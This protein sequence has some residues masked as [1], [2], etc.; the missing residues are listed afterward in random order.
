MTTSETV[1][2]YPLHAVQKGMLFHYLAA[3]NREVYLMQLL[4]DFRQPV[5]LALL[6]EAWHHVFSRHD[7]LRARFRWEG[8]KEPLQEFTEQI[9]LPVEV[10]DW[11]GRTE[12][13]QAHALESFLVTDRRAGFDLHRAPLARL[14]AIRRDEAATW[15]VFTNHHLIM[16]GRGR[17]VVLEEFL[18]AYD[19]LRAG[20]PPPAI[21]C[22]QYTDYLAWYSRQEFSGSLPYWRSFLEGFYE[23][24]SI[25]AAL[26]TPLV[27]QQP[28]CWGVQSFDIDP[29]TGES[30]R[31]L[32]AD[33]GLTLNTLFQAA[34]SLLLCRYTGL[35]D[36]V[37]GATRAARA[38][39][40]EHADDVVGLFINTLPVRAR[41]GDGLKVSTWLR[42]IRRQQVSVREHEQTPLTIVQQCSNVQ[43]GV[44]LF[45]TIMVFNSEHPVDALA[46]RGH[47][48]PPA[49]E[50]Y[51]F[52]NYPVT[53]EIFASPRIVV[54]LDHDTHVID[55]AAAARMATHLHTLLLGVRDHFDGRV[56]DIPMLDA[57]ERR[58]L[59]AT[60]AGP[61]TE[62]TGRPLVHELV[63][64]AIHCNGSQAAVEFDEESLSYR[65]VDERAAGIAVELRRLGVKPDDIVGVC[66]ERSAM[67]P[68]VVLGIL[69]SGAAYAPLDPE[70]PAERLEYI[71]ADTRTPIIISQR[72]LAPKLAS[73]RGE[74]LYIDDEARWRTPAAEWRAETPRDL[75]P[76]QLAYVIYTSGSTG[77]PKGVEMTHEVVANLID[78]QLKEPGFAAGARTLQFASL[79]FDVSFQEILS[80][81]SSGGCLVMVS[82]TDR[83]DFRQLV[84]IVARARVQRMFLPFIA[85]QQLA[86]EV[87]RSQAEFSL[88]E[89]ITA[90]EQLQTTEAIRSMFERLPR[91]TLQNQYGPSETHVVTAHTVTGNVAQWPALPPIGRPIQNTLAY[92]VGRHGEPAPI[93]V[94]GELYLGGVCVA[95]GYRNLATLTAERFVNDPFI[96]G[97]GRL[98]RTGDLA[99][100][101]P[102]GTIE[103]L[104]RADTQVKLRG[105]RIELGEIEAVLERHPVV[106]Q[107]VVALREDA[108]GRKRL[109]AYVVPVEE[110]ALTINELKALLR[111]EVPEYMIPAAFVLMDALPITPSGKI[112]RR[113]LPE[114]ARN[115][116][117]DA[118]DLVTPRDDI[119]RGLQEIWEDVLGVSPIGMTESFFDL[120]G[121]SLLAL[122][123]TDRIFD[124]FGVRVHLNTLWYEGATIE[125]LATLIRNPGERKDS[126]WITPLNT[127][128]ITPPLYCIHTVGGGNLFHYEPMVRHLNGGRT[129]L[130]VEARG[131]S[132][133]Q[134]ADTNIV[135]MGE[136]CM[137]VIQDVQPA[138]PYYL[139][140]FSSGGVV[141]YEVAQQLR[142]RG[143]SIAL[144]AM[145]DSIN[146]STIDTLEDYLHS[147][148]I[149]HRRGKYREIQE[150]TYHYFLRRLGLGGLRR[151]RTL[152]E[153]HRWAL[154][155]YV[156]EPYDG[157]VL[158][159]EAT[160][161]TRRFGDTHLGWKDLVRGRLEVVP[162]T[163]THGLIVKGESAQSIAHHINARLEELAPSHA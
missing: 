28:R 92:I 33:N 44:P 133:G 64:D 58:Q 129:I 119:E 135:A 57:E 89:I 116:A 37:F 84:A 62:S 40:V 97:G 36:V 45:D 107:S 78:W 139:C 43:P 32:A 38:H 163:G 76:Q 83:R 159:F 25:A 151:L 41:F 121:H 123:L 99:R 74:I 87:V 141:A 79:N 31:K 140:G 23:P 117:N 53:V 147:L 128:T 22:A 88:S 138:G 8:L 60:G 66:L 124:R 105:F 65:D 7:A 93:E 72:D 5:D 1:P 160:E 63:D 30:L 69:R 85:L 108:K 114:P 115:E 4:M 109:V 15:L 73:H 127:G 142:M 150:R 103:F 19:A 24:S 110:E 162:V 120:G 14:S 6:R 42:E 77:R 158:L 55:E 157:D 113:A 145:V 70:Y 111:K 106:R 75:S 10:I 26:P 134:A 144:L 82:E 152:G 13:D 81:W 21:P 148:P 47:D 131:V 130:G 54:R 39:T 29:E 100:F 68:V 96:G 156:P 91:C 149:L 101:A 137:R 27:K 52:T 122:P 132:D 118:D 56:K 94:A 126:V 12:V 46:R 50:V 143:E 153:S 161:S 155:S 112:N 136:H 146:P 18:D 61:G 9:S 17:Q 2:A 86:E 35:E 34:W 20:E 104:G 59:L 95:R 154:W 67:L 16:D 102:D 51:G 48:E 3:D 49:V 125:Y 80:T 71:L 90:G 98:Y 11:R